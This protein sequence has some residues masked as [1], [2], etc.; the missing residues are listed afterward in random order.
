MI[1]IVK[2]T[3]YADTIRR[4]KIVEG[5]PD[6][7]GLKLLSLVMPTLDVDFDNGTKTKLRER[8][9][10][11][12]CKTKPEEGKT[13]PEEGK[14][15]PEEGKAKPEEGKMKP[16][17]GKTKPEEGKTKP[18]EDDNEL[19]GRVRRMNEMKTS[20]AK[21]KVHL[22]FPRS[23]YVPYSSTG[24]SDAEKLDDR[25]KNQALCRYLQRPEKLGETSRAT[26]QN[27][28]SNTGQQYTSSHQN[29]PSSQAYYELSTVQPL[30]ERQNDPPTQANRRGSTVKPNP[31]KQGVA[32]ASSRLQGI[33]IPELWVLLI[34][35]EG[36]QRRVIGKRLGD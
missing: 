10:Q 30:S 13:K 27:V 6:C 11:E 14:T 15:K 1:V 34:F 3:K 20:Y 21:Q 33:I 9:A 22:H 17:E 29:A 8:V 5:L 23:L 25:I 19:L 7:P 2:P 4:S 36:K 12:E 31:Q 24:H 28:T 32:V 35:M 16:E 26:K 18:V